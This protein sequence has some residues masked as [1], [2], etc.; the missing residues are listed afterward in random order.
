M[1]GTAQTSNSRPDSAAEAGTLGPFGL[2]GGSNGPM[3]EGLGL[4]LERGQDAESGRQ[5]GYSQ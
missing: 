2:G 4:G 5:N 1:N 3:G